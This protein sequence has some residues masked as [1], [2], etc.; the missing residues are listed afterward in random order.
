MN[1]IKL[2]IADFSKSIEINPNYAMAYFNRGYWK[3]NI[4]QTD[5]ALSDL[6]KAKELDASNKD[7]FLELAVVYAKL[8]K[9][10]EACNELLKAVSL[11]HPMSE[12]LKAQFCK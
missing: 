5:D 8:N 7:I 1:E 10:N 3:D 6:L 4:G 11:G 9:L 12:D 2:A